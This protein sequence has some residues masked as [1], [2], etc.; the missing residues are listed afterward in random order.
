[1]AKVS[2][3]E[4]NWSFLMSQRDSEFWTRARRARD[5]LTDRFIRHPDVTGVDIGYAP[6]RGQETEEMVLRI[7]VRERWINADPATRV[8]FPE[9]VEGISVVIVPGEPFRFESDAPPAS[10][11]FNHLG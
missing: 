9:Q 1:M 6:D 3:R 11:E 8:A 4:T 7:H 5:V 10:E 2:A